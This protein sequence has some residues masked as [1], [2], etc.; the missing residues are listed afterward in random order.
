[1]TVRQDAPEEMR[2]VALQI[3]K[4][5]GFRPIQMREIMCGVLRKLPDKNN[6]SEYPNIDHEVRDLF[7]ECPWYSVYDVLE[8]LANVLRAGDKISTSARGTEE[9]ADQFETEVNRYFRQSGVGWQFVDGRIEVRGAEEFED[10]LRGAVQVLDAT[11]LRTARRELHEA[12]ADLSR[13]PTADITGAIQ[14]A[15]AALECVAREAT[16]DPK[17]TL[18]DI[19]KKN[20]G[21]IPRP[22][23]T[24]VEKAW[25][26]A[27]ERARHLRE[28]DIPDFS[29]AEFVVGLSGLCCRYLAQKL[30]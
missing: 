13:R 19:L 28:G 23:D 10:A 6:W 25:G 26:Y 17:S 30:E 5:V 16:G 15:I 8:A 4:E 3:A 2:A 21:L 7:M 18:G 12:L 27:S 14:H 22:L 11:G 29:D 1:M 20:P 9:L 24:A